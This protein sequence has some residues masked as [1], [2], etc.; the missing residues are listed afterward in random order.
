MA[1]ELLTKEGAFSLFTWILFVKTDVELGLLA[2]V[3]IPCISGQVE[4][5]TRPLWSDSPFVLPV[6]L[7]FD[8]H[9][10]FDYARVQDDQSGVVWQHSL[11][12]KAFRQHNEQEFTQAIGLKVG[13]AS[14]LPLQVV[15]V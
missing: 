5:I 9:L 8:K 15:I 6:T 13:P 2:V 1:H 7:S 4:G 11:P 10:G 12:V 3:M 14:F